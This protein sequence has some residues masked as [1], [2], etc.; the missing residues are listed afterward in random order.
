MFPRMALHQDHTG[1]NRDQCL[2][3]EEGEC[4][5]WGFEKAWMDLGEVRSIV[6]GKYDQNTLIE[7]SKN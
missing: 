6:G 1:T 7:F 3:K 4:E 2:F 5:V